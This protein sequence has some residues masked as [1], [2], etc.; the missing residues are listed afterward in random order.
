LRPVIL[1]YSDFV[2]RCAPA[3][4]AC[5]IGRGLQLGG[6]GWIGGCPRV[7]RAHG[8]IAFAYGEIAIAKKRR[9]SPGEHSTGSYIDTRRKIHWVPSSTP[10][11]HQVAEHDERRPRVIPHTRRPSMGN[12]ESTVGEWEPTSTLRTR[13]YI[14]LLCLRFGSSR[15][16]LV[17]RCHID[18]DAFAISQGI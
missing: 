14:R 3:L 2:L 4:R 6:I 12:Q 11:N 18:N 7:V 13:R 17:G 5:K 8:K 16:A 10:A 9:G 15:N 1:G